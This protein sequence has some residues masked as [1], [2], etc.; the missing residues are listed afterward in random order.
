MDGCFSLTDYSFHC[1]IGASQPRGGNA[2]QASWDREC[3]GAPPEDF[4]ISQTGNEPA[5]EEKVCQFD[6]ENDKPPEGRRR[7]AQLGNLWNAV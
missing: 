5:K 4:E 7:I 3:H 2:G 6:G 1:K